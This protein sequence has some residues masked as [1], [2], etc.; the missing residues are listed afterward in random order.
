MGQ[1]SFG[2]AGVSFRVTCHF[3]VM[4]VAYFAGRSTSAIVRASFDSSF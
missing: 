1:L 4:Y 2:P 3:P